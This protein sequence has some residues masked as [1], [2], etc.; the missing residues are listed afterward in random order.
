MIILGLDPAI[1]KTGWGVIRAENS[2]IFYIAS[3]SIVTKSEDL[4]PRRLSYISD[5]I[6]KI[7]E[8]YNPTIAA[9]EEIFVNVNPHSSIKLAHARGAIMSEVGKSGI[10][11][12]EFAPNKIKKTITGAGKADKEQVLYMVNM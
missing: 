4:M 5:E 2:S 3:G 6:H 12:R 7:I 11:L 9:M 8:L 1:T 10:E